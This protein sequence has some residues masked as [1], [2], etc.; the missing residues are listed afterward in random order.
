MHVIKILKFDSEGPG[1]YD[2]RDKHL[3]N[4]VGSR[5]WK[6]CIH[7]R[8]LPANDYSDINDRTEAGRRRS[9]RAVVND[10]K[11]NP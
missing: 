2:A 3:A 11:N 1:R 10:E 9:V 5:H 7:V 4:A 8:I 6:H